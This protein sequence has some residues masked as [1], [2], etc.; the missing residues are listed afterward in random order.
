MFKRTKVC[1]GVIVALGGTLAL[2]GLPALA[3]TSDRVEVTGSRI[4]TIGAVSNSPI[5]SVGAE[6]INSNQPAAIWMSRTRYRSDHVG[7]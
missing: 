5:T 3:Q 7:R 1:S 4:R 2:A 6:E